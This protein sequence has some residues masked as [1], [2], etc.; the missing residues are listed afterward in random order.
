MAGIVGS[1]AARASGGTVSTVGGYTLHTFTAGSSS[2]TPATTGFIDVLAIG[3]GGGCGPG[4]TGPS[5]GSAGGAGAVI[6]RKFVPVVAGTPYPIVVGPGGAA[7]PGSPSFSVGNPGGNTTISISGI[8]TAYGGGAGGANGNGA[9]SPS[10]FA[11]GG[12]GGSY[13]PAGPGGNGGS[14]Y[15]AIGYGFPGFKGNASR[16]GGG[17]GGAGGGGPITTE[18]TT[19]GPG[20][21]IGY[22]TGVPTDFAGVG[23]SV[24]PGATTSPFYGSGGSG[25]EYPA[26]F[27][28]PA[29]RPGVVFIRYI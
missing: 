25:F 5:G 19:G 2:F 29:G 13:Y 21:P 14:G 28:G 27:N 1:K 15:G 10:P 22:M 7:S 17:G 11:S 24:N 26:Y 12:G 16:S 6:Y 9:G 18:S 8:T 4:G 3:G 20:V 23:G